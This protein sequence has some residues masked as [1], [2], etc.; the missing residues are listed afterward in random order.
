MRRRLRYLR[1]V[2]ELSYRDLGGLMFDLHRFGGRRDEL[3]A[4]KLGRLGEVDSELRAI[5]NVL[6]QRQ[7]VTVLREAGVLACLRCAAIHSSEDNYCPHCGL[8]VSPS[9]ER[10]LSTAP[11]AQPG[12]APAPAG[13]TAPS[14]APSALPRTPGVPAPAQP[15][16][17]P[18]PPTFVQA[19]PA[20]TPPRQPPVAAPNPALTSTPGSASIAT[21]ATPPAAARAAGPPAGTDGVGDAEHSDEIENTVLSKPAPSPSEDIENTMLSPT[22]AEQPD[23]G[24]EPTQVMR[25]PEPPERSSAE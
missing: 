18:A 16:T 12:A 13:A 6:E 20:P 8:S 9:A 10:P 15:Q 2:R 23:G 11:E 21:S 25:R 1:T 24:D 17:P 7:P 22:P 19:A 14:L 3:L 4:A 5:E